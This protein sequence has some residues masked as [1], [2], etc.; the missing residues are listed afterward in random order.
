[1]SENIY[2]TNKKVFD[3]WIVPYL[4]SRKIEDILVHGKNSYYFL[5]SN[6][7]ITV[8]TS[9]SLITITGNNLSK[10]TI[11]ELEALLKLE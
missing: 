10:N 7:L 2:H 8:N 11:N 1:M 5:T 9:K 4:I 3:E 6:Q